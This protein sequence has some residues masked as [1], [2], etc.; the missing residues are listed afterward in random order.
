MYAEERKKWYRYAYAN[1]ETWNQSEY[2]TVVGK[3]YIRQRVSGIA[4]RLTWAPHHQHWSVDDWKNVAC[5]DES[6]FQLNRADGRIRVWRHESMDPTCHQRTVQAGGGSMMDNAM[7]HTSRIA[8]DW[9]QEHS[10]EFI[11][12]R[13]PPKSL[14]MNI[15]EHILDALQRAVQ[16]R[17]PTPLTPIYGQPCRIHGVSITSSTTSD[18]N[19]IHTTSCCDTSATRY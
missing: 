10:T 5:S 4:L 18:I 3:A 8:T 2:G 16:K 19:R 11:H 6:R 17:F 1:K 14:D 9:L 7:P 15:I 13:W 12:I